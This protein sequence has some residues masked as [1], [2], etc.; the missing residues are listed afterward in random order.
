MLQVTETRLLSVIAFYHLAFLAISMAMLGMTAGALF[1]HFRSDWFAPASLLSNLAWIASAFAISVVASGLL[2]ISTVV[3]TSSGAKV[4][5]VLA[6]LKLILILLPPYVLAGMAISLALTRSPWPVG[7]VYGVDLLGA[8]SGCLLVLVL[9]TWMDAVSTLLAVG[10]V[11]AVAAVCFAAAAR[12]GGGQPAQLPIARMAIL[13][14][15]GWLAVAL[16]AAAGIN[17][18]IHP[19]GLVLTSVHNRLEMTFPAAMHWNSFSRIRAEWPS[20]G[21][22]MMWGASP[23]MPPREVSQLNMNIDGDAGTPLYRFGGDIA[24]VDFLRYDVT[25]LAYTIRHQGRAAVIGVGGGRDLLSAYLFGFRDVTGVELNPIFIDLLRNRFHEYNRLASL[26]GMRLIVDEARSWFARTPERFDVV[27]MSLIDTWAATGAGAMSL[28]ENGLYTVQGWQHFL[29]ALAPAGV[30]TVSRWYDPQNVTETGRLLSL[31]MAALRD[32]GVA[33]PASHVYM[34]GSSNLA[35]LIVSNAPFTG[36]ELAVLDRRVQELGFTVLLSP[37]RAVGNAVLRQIAEAVTPADYHALS[38][39]H[40]LDMAPPTD[41]RPFFFNQLVLTDPESI[42]IA[43]RAVGGVVRGNLLATATVAIIIVLSAILV[44]LTMVV[45]ALP[46][47]RAVPGQLAW[48]GTLYF[49]LIGLGFMFIEIGLIQR[50]SVFLGHPIYGLAIGL[51]GIILSTGLGSLLSE[52]LPLDVGNRFALWA[53]TLAAYVALMTWWFPALVLAF[54]GQNTVVRAIVALV[55]IMPPGIL[56]GFG[57]PAGMRLVNAIDNRP[58]PWFWAVNGAA[59]VL[60][61][62]VAIGISILHSI[63]ASLWVGAA[64]YLLLTPIGLVLGSAG[65]RIRH[66][67][68]QTAE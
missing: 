31:A 56:M 65:A 38:R 26:P 28:S 66:A 62:S 48:L 10:A 14:S 20:D 46:T 55:A 30:F 2:L 22:P 59:G 40:H 39:Q 57:F 45:P 44:L 67:L 53:A 4:M 6:W 11:G 33:Q 49:G 25:T 61:A 35:T 43:Q 3:I 19:R 58:T 63:N 54:E 5:T 7:L 50:L 21:P 17:A 36:Q 52:R 64:C 13:R 24:D 51:F 12:A 60:A 34:A 1:M 32:R 41:D 68:L 15:P 9:L 27:Q 16:V 47:V 18:V 37:D 29:G 23:N 8:A 42:R